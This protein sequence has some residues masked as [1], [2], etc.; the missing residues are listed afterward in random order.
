M[1]NCAAAPKRNNMG[2][3]RSGPKSIMAPMPIKSRIG[4]AS[5]ASIPIEKSHSIIPFVSKV[6]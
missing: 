3:D 2:F 1:P 6:P 4:N 5:E